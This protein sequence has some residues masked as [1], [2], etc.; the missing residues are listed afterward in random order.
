MS[1]RNSINEVSVIN[2]ITAAIVHHTNLINYY[3][4]VV[5]TEPNFRESN[6][7]RTWSEVNLHVVDQMW[8]STAC[9]WGGMGG[10]A[11]T[12]KHNVILEHPRE[13]I[14]FVYWDGRLAYI[15]DNKDDYFSFNRMPSRSR[16]IENLIYEPS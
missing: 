16:E 3:S 9:G 11:M 8:G 5:K 1:M 13:K 12:S 10:S 2:D 4:S 15:L 14:L 6:L 7:Y